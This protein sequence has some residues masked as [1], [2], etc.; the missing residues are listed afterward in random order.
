MKSAI[1][2]AGVA[3]ALG[4][5]YLDAKYHITKDIG[6]LS[7]V[8]TARRD[9]RSRG[10]VR[11]GQVSLWFRFLESAAKFPASDA[12]WTRE[13]CYTFSECLTRCCQ[14]ASFL[15]DLGVV[16]G[17]AVAMY[18]YNSPDFLF[19]WLACYAVGCS[20]TF[21]N[22]NLTGNALLHTWQV[23][24]T[25]FLIADGDLMVNLDCI[26]EVLNA[27]QRIVILSEAQKS[28][29]YS[30]APQLPDDHLARSVRPDDQTDAVSARLH[31]KVCT[32]PG[33]NGDRWYICMPLYHGTGG[34]GAIT[35]L[36]GGITV[37][38]VEKFSVT[39]FWEDIRKSRAT[40][41]IYVGETARY[42]LSPPPSP[43]DKEHNLQVMFGNGMRPDVWTK[44][45]DRFAVPMI[46]EFFGAS[47]GVFGLQTRAR[48]PFLAHS[49]GHDG[50]LIRFIM[51]NKYFAAA[52]DP[53]SGDIQRD[54]VTGLVV[55]SPLTTGGEILFALEK[56]KDFRGYFDNQEATEKRLSRNVRC[57]GDLYYRTGDA[58]R[59]DSEGRWFFMDRLGD[60]FRWKSENV[61][62]S[63]VSGIF[64][65][66]P[67]IKEAVIYGVLIPHHD[68]RA[69]C[70]RVVI[71]EQ[72][73]PHFDY[74]S[75]A[76]QLRARLPKYAVPIFLR[77][78]T[79]HAPTTG[80]NK[81]VKG[82]L[83]EE[84]IDHAKFANGDKMLWLLPEADAYV[85]FTPTDYNQLIMGKIKL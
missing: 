39:K 40:L 54:P 35:A 62:T 46:V 43:L 50:L 49:V 77:V 20:P 3:V 57:P 66:F 19:M 83:R 45:Q 2:A 56:E 79:T 41:C 29:I 25:N 70:A 7:E 26:K 69:G 85:E 38:L 30:L 59:R 15:R 52:I 74:R 37:C 84:G 21:L 12:I 33:P 28:S 16:T 10:V 23:A 61:C 44:F 65:S 72:D 68:G 63:E 42:L 67:K 4:S 64:G 48:G 78:S 82:Q 22:Y 5:A 58:L 34:I 76:S 31:S 71:T 73:Q 55:E 18:M 17:Q 11:K 32:T 80:N 75:L 9:T 36:C 13:R 47:E 1:G 53:D 51:R 14:Y 6:L 8:I 60:T 27:N 81:I 24:K